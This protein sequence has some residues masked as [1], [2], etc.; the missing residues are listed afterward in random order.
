MNTSIKEMRYKKM[1]EVIFDDSVY[2]QTSEIFNDWDNAVEY[3][4]NYAETET[5][6]AGELVDRLT[7]E[8]VW[9]FGEEN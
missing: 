2:G 1:Y 7:G 9:S 6:V 4:Q 3:W 5:C 8:V